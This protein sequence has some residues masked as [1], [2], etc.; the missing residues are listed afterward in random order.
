VYEHLRADVKLL[1]ELYELARV[2]P[3]VWAQVSPAKLHR[4]LEALCGELCPA[5]FSLPQ[6]TE[7]QRTLSDKV[8]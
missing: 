8:V 7:E 2:A 5:L 3:S 6:A 4:R 1:N